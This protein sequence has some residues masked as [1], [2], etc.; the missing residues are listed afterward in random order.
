MDGAS[1]DSADELNCRVR[2]TKKPLSRRSEFIMAAML[3]YDA[4]TNRMSPSYNRN[5]GSY[6]AEMVDLDDQ[7]IVNGPPNMPTINNL[8]VTRSS[9]VHFGPK[10]TNVNQTVHSTEVIKGRILGLELVSTNTAPRLRCTVAVFVCWALLVA[11]ALAFCILYFALYKH[12]TLLD[13][14]LPMSTYLCNIL[15][16]TTLTERLSCIV[17]TVAVIICIIVLIV[18]VMT[19]F[20]TGSNT[21]DV[22]PHEWNITK[23][24][25]LAHPYNYTET[26]KE[27]QPI[28]LVIIQHTVSTECHKFIRCA[29]EIR[30]IQSWYLREY[31][32]DIPYNFLVGNDGRIYEGRGWGIVGAHTKFYNR[33]SVGIGFIGDYREDAGTQHTKVTQL[34]VNRTLMFL[35]A[36]VEEGHL[37]PNYVV[38]GAKDLQST[39]SPGANLYKAI[40]QWPHYD[41]NKRYRNKTCEEI[42]VMMV[43]NY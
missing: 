27:F 17:A 26:T 41:D 5:Y 20:K 29:A 21:V 25:W 33:C 31:N 22:A 39:E 19:G 14:D 18:Y 37:D 2:G 42:W 34:Q 15:K 24:M 16:S 7:P 3:W 40:Q 32:Y 11:S 1:R 36:S 35:E 13:I 9:R 38:M 12:Q 4:D 28:K 8:S 10:I 6:T 43:E 23:E 30:N